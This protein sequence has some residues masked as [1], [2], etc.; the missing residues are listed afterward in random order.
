MALARCPIP[1]YDG[2]IGV[3]NLH[4][5]YL[6]SKIL[7][8]HDWYNGGWSDPAYQVELCA[9]DFPQ[10]QGYL[11]GAP[12]PL[13]L[14]GITRA[15]LVAWRT[16]LR[17]VHWENRLTRHTHHC[18]WAKYHPCPVSGNGTLSGSRFWGTSG[19]GTTLGPLLTCSNDTL[20]APNSI[21]I[22]RCGTLLPHTYPWAPLSLNLALKR[23]RS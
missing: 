12:I 22:C 13:D 15:A 8:I 3:T 19:L 5:F 17:Y 11:Y 23:P 7:A 2:G 20:L 16:A 10:L 9:M 6:A 4:L 18:G 21:N 1:P 14:L